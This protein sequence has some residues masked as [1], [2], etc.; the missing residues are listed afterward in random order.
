MVP[1]HAGREEVDEP[2]LGIVTRLRPY[3]AKPHFLLS[4]LSFLHSPFSFLVLGL[5][6]VKV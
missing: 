6:G 4:P 3:L 1:E 5:L 2:F